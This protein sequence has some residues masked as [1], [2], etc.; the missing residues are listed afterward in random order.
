RLCDALR[1]RDRQGD[2]PAL[3]AHVRQR[4]HPGARP[5]RSRRD[6]APVRHGPRQGSDPRSSGDRSDLARA[7]L[8]AVLRSIG[9]AVVIALTLLP[10][11][12]LSRI[13]LL[14]RVESSPTFVGRAEAAARELGLTVRSLRVGGVDQYEN[15]FKTAQRGARRSG[16]GAPVADLRRAAPY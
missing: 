9:L 1:A 5:R 10:A 16:P 15:A 3:R 6:R 11:P 8:R 12:G 14:A 13:V 4:L 7:R 2:V